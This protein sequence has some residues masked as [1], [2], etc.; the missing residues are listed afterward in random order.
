[1]THKRIFND[2]KGRR[3]YSSL[4]G[5][6]NKTTWFFRWSK[7]TCFKCISLITN[8]QMRRLEREGVKIGGDFG[9]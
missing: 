7:V 1:M 5:E 6:G 3:K 2:I 4:C 9:V 8:H